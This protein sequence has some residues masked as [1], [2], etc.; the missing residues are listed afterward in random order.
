VG[1]NPSYLS[2]P[3]FHAGYFNHPSQ[4]Q[5]GSIYGS[6]S[7]SS[8]K[9]PIVHNMPAKFLSPQKGPTGY[10]MMSYAR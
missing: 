4:S 8:M 6:S 3:D 10:S 9:K 7:A 1:Y 2:Y 5:I